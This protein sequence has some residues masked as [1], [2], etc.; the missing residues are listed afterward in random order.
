MAKISPGT[1]TAAIF[2]ILLGL[3]GAYTVRQYLHEKPTIE[4]VAEQQRARQ[5]IVPIA[6]RDIQPGETLTINDIVIRS[7]SPE[8]FPNTEYAKQSFMP[9]TKQIMERMVKEEIKAGAVFLP[10]QFY[11][12]NQGPTI[13]ELLKPGYR[14]VTVPIENIGAVQG[15]ARPGSVVD[16]LFRAQLGD[17]RPEVT[18]TLLEGVN[19]LALGQ[20]II[21]GQVV[22]MN[23]RQSSAGSVTLAVLPTQA[24]SLKVAEGRG[25]ISL[26]LRHPDEGMQLQP[27][28]KMTQSMTLE[29]LVGMPI[30]Q[31]RKVEI[32]RAAQKQVVEFG[33][34][35]DSYNDPLN[36][37]INSPVVNDRA[38]PKVTSPPANSV[39][40]VSGTTAQ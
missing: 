3:A 12:D 10:S 36:Q 21:P 13:A 16:V 35:V 2:A 25:E 7:F 1:M 37:L 4:E 24:Q 14:A 23:D 27:V 38:T 9:N 8:E 33:G 39:S 28:S 40:Q 20:N 5:V 29:E 19:V 17:D 18:I 31:P 34:D 30:A 26:A 11:P 22:D 32:Y 6:A 15:Y